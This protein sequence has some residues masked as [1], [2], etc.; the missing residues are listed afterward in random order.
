MSQGSTLCIWHMTYDICHMTS[1]HDRLTNNHFWDYTWKQ[2]LSQGSTLSIWYHDIMTWQHD[3]Q[4]L[5]RLDM[6]TKVVQ[7]VPR[8]SIK[9]IWHHD[10]KTCQHEKQSLLRLQMKTKVIQHVPRINIKHLTYDIIISWFPAFVIL[11]F[12]SWKPALWSL[13]SQGRV[14]RLLL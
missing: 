1:W 8:I 7:Y 11:T 14:L 4:S 13:H 2:K 12:F 6:K 10:M 5:L 3:K 9:S